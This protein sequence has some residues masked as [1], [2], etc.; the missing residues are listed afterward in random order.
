MSTLI[1]QQKWESFSFVQKL[2]SATVKIQLWMDRHHQR[3]QL[4]GLGT[5]QLMDMGLTETQVKQETS[6]PFWK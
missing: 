2:V 6:K 3:K 5:D 4:A 1:L